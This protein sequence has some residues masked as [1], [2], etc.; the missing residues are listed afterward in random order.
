MREAGLMSRRGGG[1]SSAVDGART[2]LRNVL[3]SIA[4]YGLSVRTY[5]PPSSSYTCSKCSSRRMPQRLAIAVAV[6]RLSPVTMRTS[7]PARK[8]RSMAGLTS[9]R[10]GSSI[11]AIA[12]RVSE[13]ST[14]NAFVPGGVRVGVRVEGEG[15]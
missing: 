5:S 15:H 2:I 11:P 4:R 6:S 12:T 1:P 7:M 8:Q 3:P 14:A 9:G 13:V 10:S